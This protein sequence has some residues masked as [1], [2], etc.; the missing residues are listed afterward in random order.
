MTSSR[1]T[2]MSEAGSTRVLESLT[3]QGLASHTDSTPR[4]FR[5]VPLEV[6]TGAEALRQR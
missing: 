4:L 1:R 2:G 3:R 5:A 6:I